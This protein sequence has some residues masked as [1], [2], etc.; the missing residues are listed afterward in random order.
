MLSLEKVSQR[1]TAARG[2][3][4]LLTSSKKILFGFIILLLLVVFGGL[5][6]WLAPFDPNEQILGKAYLPP[7]WVSGSLSSHIFG[8]DSLGR[9]VFSRLLYGASV[10]LYVAVAA[11]LLTA[12]IGVPLG[13][14]S[15]YL[16]GKF[17]EVV[18]RAV[19]IWMSFPPVL[20]AITLI[21]ILGTGLN[22]VIL[23]I[24]VV[25]W[26]RFTRVIRSEVLNIREKDFVL[27]AR[28]IGFSSLQIMR[29]EVLPNVVPLI[30]IIATLEMSVA[31]TV[32][33][34]LSYAGLGVKADTPSWGSM[35]SDGLSYFRI[36]PW[37]M[38]IPLIATII[39]ILGL[40]ILGDG[41]REK[42][43][44]RLSLTR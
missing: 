38:A 3:L 18:M 7:F 13:I 28:S 40:N 25:D 30:S 8:T 14:A 41:L 34:L 16:R 37:G 20:L 17:D 22:N 19:D 35:I 5:A 39:V 2:A 36:S 24:V 43:D 10:A 33:V 1:L 23:A 4:N 44:P 26:T 11:T 27:A 42:L 6:P 9:D 21:S 32:E 31:I 15:G 12:A 29:H